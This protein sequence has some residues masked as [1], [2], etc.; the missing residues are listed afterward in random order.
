M[1]RFFDVPFALNGDKTTIPDGLQL[2]G[3]VSYEEGFGFDYE[4]PAIDPLTGQPDPLYKPVPRDGTNTLFY[5]VT[6]ALGVIQRQGFADWTTDAG[7]YEANSWVRHNG[8]VWYAQ[9]QTSGEPGISPDWV[10]LPLPSS[11]YAVATGAANAYAATY[12]PSIAALTDGM[13]LSFRVPA[14]NTGASTLNANGLGAK[15]VRGL[16]GALQGGELAVGG[17][18]RVVYNQPLDA[19]VLAECGG[20]ALQ[21]PDAVKSQQAITRGQVEA[22]IAAIPR[23]VTIAKTYFMGQN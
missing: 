23:G 4:R 11:R 3:S 2:D 10:S 6:D 20:G 22:L 12:Q 7:T 15:T 13:E 5:E 1:A 9:V 21:V 14:A 19:F 16:F 18:A 17:I 8:S